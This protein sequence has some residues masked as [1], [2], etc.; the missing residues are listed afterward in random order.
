MVPAYI[1]TFAGMVFPY[2]NN[3]YRNFELGHATELQEL[4]NQGELDYT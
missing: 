2:M 3:P 4:Y 1:Y